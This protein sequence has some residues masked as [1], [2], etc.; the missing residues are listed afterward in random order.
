MSRLLIATN[1]RGKLIELRNIFQGLPCEIVSPADIGID[2]EVEETGSIF[3]E[4]AILKSVAF[5]RKSGLLALA[6]DS[7]LEVKALGGKPGVLSARYAGTDATDTDRVKFLLSQMLDVPLEKRQA[8]FRSVI[9]ITDPNDW[10]TE[11]CSGECPGII[12]FEPR[13]LNGFG[14][15]PIFYL[16]QLSKTMAELSREVKN[17]I[18]HRGQAARNA[19]P[20]LKN[21]LNIHKFT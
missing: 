2:L 3:E 7:G 6:D 12:T 5:A 16:P 1:N 21:L 20:I 19:I 8:R 17:S 9:A 10:H 14:Y 4:N 18:S 11:L 15:D 13:G